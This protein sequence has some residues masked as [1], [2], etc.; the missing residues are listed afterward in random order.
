M[1]ESKRGVA[2]ASCIA[3][4]GFYLMLV[5]IECFVLLNFREALFQ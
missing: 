3:P 2:V 4:K 5:L 1:A